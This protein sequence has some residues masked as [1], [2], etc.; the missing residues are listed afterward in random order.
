MNYVYR[1][2]R[3]I[4]N[5]VP[6]FRRLYSRWRA[7]GSHVRA[8]NADYRNRLAA[9][10]R[11]YKD[12]ENI[13]VLPE[14][15][16]YWSNKYL[17]PM[18]EEYGVSNPD[19]FFAKYLHESARKS[20]AASPIF[21]SIGAGNCDT[22]VRVA[23]LLREAGLSGFV[24]ECLDMNGH[25]LQRGKEMA[26]REGVAEHIV[27]VEGDFNQWRAGKQ[28]TAI[29]ANQS[30]HHV[31]NLEGLFDEIK[32][33][34]HPNGYFITSDMI[35][36]NG[37]QRWPEAL[38]AVQNFWREL[39]S[40]YRNNRQLDRHEDVYQNW[41]C[42]VEGFEGIRAQDILPL[43]LER[44]HFV[45]YI[46]FANV[47][48]IFIDRSFGHNFDANQE[49][50]RAFVDR[51]HDYDEQAFRRGSL[52]PTHMMA[53]MTAGSLVQRSCSRGIT[54]EQSVRRPLPHDH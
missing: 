32:R 18:L 53:V 4:K 39:P 24:I 48:D 47:V 17:R 22:E 3:R 36:R 33:V 35:G 5:S 45:L 46:G 10:T 29:M 20:G 50:D 37:H 11:I 40:A 28:Y 15:F 14:I 34:V 21:V 30:L 38:E 44:F 1:A 6:L 12:V 9:E 52:T 8:D 7:I 42:S 23:K 41:D 16:H 49:W 19:Q 43:L 26:I 27:L 25:M 54:P 13:N 31:V 51:L 2:A